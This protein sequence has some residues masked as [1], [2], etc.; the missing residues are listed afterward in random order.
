M[1]AVGDRKTVNGVTGEWDGETWRRVA[2]APAEGSSSGRG[3]GPAVGT[4]KTVDGVTGEWDGTTWRRVAAPAPE[5]PPQG[6]GD[7][8]AAAGLGAAALGAIPAAVA[9]AKTLA[10]EVATNPRTVQ[11][12]NKLARGAAGHLARTVTPLAVGAQLLKGDIKGAATT[13]LG[14]AL[15]S[16]AVK[17]APAAVLRLAGAAANLLPS[18][19]AAAAPLA[20]GA[21]LGAAVPAAAL[22]AIEADANRRPTIDPTRA[23]P[24]SSIF[25]AFET[26]A[27]RSPAGGRR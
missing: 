27:G 7:A 9:G 18:G 3:A 22:A 5:A 20:A 2:A 14:G 1:P 23:T 11:V 8:V 12:V 17:R 6:S 25:R 10:E 21:G 19:A 26:M 16:A 24:A 15:T 13:G 4:R